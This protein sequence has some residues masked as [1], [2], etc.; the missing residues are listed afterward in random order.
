MAA[1]VVAPDVDLVTK[2]DNLMTEREAERTAE[3]DQVQ[4]E[5]RGPSLLPACVRSRASA[6]TWI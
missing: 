4:R 3:R 6:L 5:L 1:I 2:T